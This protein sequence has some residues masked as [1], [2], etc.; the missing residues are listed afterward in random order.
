MFFLFHESLLLDRTST[1]FLAGI[2]KHFLVEENHPLQQFFIVFLVL[3]V[4]MNYIELH[5][6]NF[7]ILLNFNINTF[8]QNLYVPNIA[9]VN[10]LNGIL[11]LVILLGEIQTI[12]FKFLLK[13]AFGT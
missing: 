7:A 8:L 4:R 5:H 13:T 10:I 9:L 2:K 1:I 12:N 6:F 3:F 11:H